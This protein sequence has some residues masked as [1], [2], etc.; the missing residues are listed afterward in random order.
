[1]C[2]PPA[3]LVWRDEEAAA[4][5]TAERTSTNAAAAREAFLQDEMSVEDIVTDFLG[6]R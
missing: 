5:D 3:D 1:M 6:I 2:A 4:G